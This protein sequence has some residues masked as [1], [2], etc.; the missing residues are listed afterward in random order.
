MNQSGR[1]DGAARRKEHAYAD[2]PTIHKDRTVLQT[3]ERGRKMRRLLALVA[4]V[5]V[6]GAALTLGGNALRAATNAGR[7]QLT[8]TYHRVW[9]AAAWPADNLAVLIAQQGPLIPSA[10]SFRAHSTQPPAHFVGWQTWT[11][12][13]VERRWRLLHGAGR[14]ATIVRGLVTAE[15]L[16]V[17][18][19]LGLALARP[20]LAGGL[21]RLRPS[22]SHGSARLASRRELRRLRPRGHGPLYLGTAQG[23]TV[24]LPEKLVYQHTLVVGPPGSGKSSGLIIPNLLRERGARSLVIVDPKNELIEC[25]YAAVRRHADPWVI[26]F[27][28]PVTSRAYNPL[29]LVGDN[30]VEAL[31]LAECWIA[32]T[33]KSQSEPFWDNAA[34]L[35]ISAAILHLN[36]VY[37]TGGGA[38][39]TDLA[40]FLSS[41]SSK[42]II[43]ALRTSPSIKARNTTHGF[44]KSMELNERLLG[45]VFTEVA[46]R[47]QLLFDE[48]IQATTS[49]Q[50]I[51][52]AE[53]ADPAR[54][55]PV[56]L[57]LALD[58]SKATILKPLTACFFMQLF[59]ALL[60][61]AYASPQKVL[62]RPVM[63]YLDEFGN[64]GAIPDMA[65][66]MTTVRSA[67][68]GCMV[69]VQ[70]LAQI[71]A[72]YGRDGKQIIITGCGTKI[73]LAMTSADDAE[74][75]S[76]QCG[77]RTVLTRTA[78]DSRKRGQA[79]AGQGNRGLSE[80]GRALFT[81]DEI[82]RMHEREM[83]VLSGNIHPIKVQQ[84]RYYEQ[85]R[86]R[87]LGTTRRDDEQGRVYPARL[88][89]LRPPRPLFVEPLGLAHPAGP[90]DEYVPAEEDYPV[91]PAPAA[92]MEGERAGAQPTTATDAPAAGD[93]RGEE[94]EPSR[95][96]VTRPLD[97]AA[98]A[99][100]RTGRT[101]A[102]TPPRRS[103][104]LSQTP[105]P[106]VDQGAARPGDQTT[107]DP[108]TTFL[109]DKL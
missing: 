41:Q 69:A 60:Q 34:R 12:V 3:G 15:A 82:T 45:S 92:A 54:P 39:L 57:Y 9:V 7:R 2:K 93:P 104:P 103:L 23:G 36:T 74:W 67:R 16:L 22:S 91:I 38:T 70:D 89:A 31:N 85:R 100:R 18:L 1:R 37:Q 4:V 75:F 61:I 40:G 6:L 58:P 107:A 66:L 5:L 72:N 20:L 11:A 48:A 83:V 21:G 53:L 73:A 63:M 101:R 97:T 30:A 105:N 84:Q 35:L 86:L 98:P 71:G 79:L 102:A 88:Q 68:I 76:K 14:Q 81:A 55:R 52:F 28:D 90:S 78:G 106:G 13:P 26:N 51:D 44:L 24:A 47:F 43:E 19:L 27:L 87:R 49:R 64:M 33:G 46:Q 25:T 94:A 8:A 29:T 32:N 95:T 17:P 96:P 80:S 65:R 10:T 59:A 62:G 50:E 42:E 77:T 109:G 108:R 99:R 56:A